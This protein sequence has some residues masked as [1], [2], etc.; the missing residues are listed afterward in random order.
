MIQNST[1]ADGDA[2]TGTGIVL[3]DTRGISLTRMWIHDHTNYAIYG[4]TVN[5]FALTNSV[6]NALSGYNGNNGDIDEASIAFTQLTGSAS[7]TNSEIRQGVEDNLRVVNTS[8][9][10]DRMTVTGSTF[11]SDSGLG[12]DNI[13]FNATDNATLNATID[14]NDFTS[15]RGD[16]IQA[17]V[18]GT[19]G[20]GDIQFI[21]N[22][23]S[24]SHPT[25]LG[26]GIVLASAGS[27][28]LTYAINNNAVSG[29]KGTAI[30]TGKL[31]GLPNDGTAVGTISGNTIGINGVAASGSELGSGI[32]V[33]HIGGGRHSVQI[34]NNTIRGYRDS[35]MLLFAGGGT[36]AGAPNDGSVNYTLTGNN[37]AQQ[38]PTTST[39]NGGI[40]LN[41]GTNS[42]G[43]GGP[44]RYQVCLN[45]S[46]NTIT[47]SA[48]A[49]TGSREL[50]LRQRFDVKV[51][52]PGYSGP[53]N[54]SAGTLTAAMDAYWTPRFNGAFTRFYSANAA[55]AT[56]GF[57]AAPGASCPVS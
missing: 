2:T 37:V 8:G 26:G 30:A 17:T 11:S 32:D 31:A 56:G 13:Y 50:I 15:V 44:D 34:L 20:K 53:A 28:D 42:T 21:N 5:G 33:S 27:G 16:H 1:G 29:S 36:L 55:S 22:R 4:T 52:L 24:N 41:A 40:H 47:G 6:V 51:F 43:E 49:P 3:N 54:D 10:L 19:N 9:S 45:V 25:D 39:G 23:V 38:N 48:S 12:N 35:G 46:N 57:F 7:I 18:Q 14:N